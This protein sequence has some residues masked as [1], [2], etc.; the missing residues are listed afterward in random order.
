M[1]DGM[2]AGLDEMRRAR[3]MD[4]EMMPVMNGMNP[5]DQGCADTARPYNKGYVD[6]SVGAGGS[7]CHIHDGFK[8]V[9]L[10]RASSTHVGQVYIRMYYTATHCNLLH[11]RNTCVVV[12]RCS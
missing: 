2:R 6:T 1:N 5:Y 9:W 8:H 4:A 12:S 7:S 3:V 10:T 11:L